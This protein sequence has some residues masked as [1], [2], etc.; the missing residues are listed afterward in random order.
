MTQ[1]QIST[2]YNNSIKFKS[3]QK[4]LILLQ[5]ILKMPRLSFLTS[6]AAGKQREMKNVSDW[7]VEEMQLMSTTESP[8]VRQI[9]NKIKMT[10]TTTKYCVL[11][12]IH[13]VNNFCCFRLMCNSYCS[14][15]VYIIEQMVESAFK[16]S[17]WQCL[18]CLFS[19]FASLFVS[20]PW[21]AISFLCYFAL[22]A[23]TC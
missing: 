4:N 21:I 9:Q 11:Y 6:C 1:V 16:K 14:I 15:I 19:W 22:I 20:W 2:K 3:N 5:L 10:G 8:S 18:L 12:T 7:D 17:P 13:I 23:L